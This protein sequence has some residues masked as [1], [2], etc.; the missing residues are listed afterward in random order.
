MTALQPV[1]AHL[2]AFPAIVADI[3]GHTDNS[4]PVD[5]SLGLSLRRA[6]SVREFVHRQGVAVERLSARGE[7]GRKPFTSNGTPEGRRLNN[8]IDVIFR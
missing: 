5:A 4:G 2:K 6:E 7:G 8:R 3:V 1:I